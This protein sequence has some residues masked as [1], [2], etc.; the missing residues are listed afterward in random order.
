MRSA[1]SSRE[2]ARPAANQL[3][4]PAPSS[5][6]AIRC[7]ARTSALLPSART[8]GRPLP[9]EP[10]RSPP[11][12]GYSGLPLTRHPR[13]RQDLRSPARPARCDSSSCGARAA[14]PAAPLM[15]V[16]GPWTSG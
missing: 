12:A 16:A 2:A 15:Q 4:R 10:A 9:Q 5:I 1:T 6:A 11:G 7:S 3:A 8:E 13:V 14:C